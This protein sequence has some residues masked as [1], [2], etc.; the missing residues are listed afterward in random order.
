MTSLSELFYSSNITYQTWVCIQS[1]T[2]IPHVQSAPVDN[3]LLTFQR[4]NQGKVLNS[5][6]NMHL[7]C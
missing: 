1:H 5:A 3:P 7:H 6:H 2:V 4:K